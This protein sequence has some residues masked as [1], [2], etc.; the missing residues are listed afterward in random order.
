MAGSMHYEDGPEDWIS[1]SGDPV[2]H[3]DRVSVSGGGVR[4]A[5]SRV[6]TSAARRFVTAGG[7]ATPRHTPRRGT[8]L[9]L[10]QRDHTLG[11]KA[12]CPVPHLRPLPAKPGSVNPG[13]QYWSPHHELG[14]FGEQDMLSETARSYRKRPEAHRTLP[15]SDVSHGTGTGYGANTGSSQQST[16]TYKDNVDTFR[17]TYN[18]FH[19][20]GH[21]EPRATLRAFHHSSNLRGSVPLSARSRSRTDHLAF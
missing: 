20:D 21:L 5:P 15:F 6:L 7:A 12:D 3:E 1:V 19:A 2:Q 4:P 14:R 16:W 8:G 18:D 17:T 11:E 10:S 13:S 9:L